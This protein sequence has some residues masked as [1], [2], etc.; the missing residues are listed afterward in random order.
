[1]DRAYA[2]IA[3]YEETL[4]NTRTIPERVKQFEEGLA[5]LDTYEGEDE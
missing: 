5:H 1:V 2:I 4:K 3:V